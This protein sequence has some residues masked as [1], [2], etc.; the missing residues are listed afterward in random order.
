MYFTE[1]ITLQTINRLNIIRMPY[2][3][4]KYRIYEKIVR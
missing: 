2:V 4:N 1:P 3:K